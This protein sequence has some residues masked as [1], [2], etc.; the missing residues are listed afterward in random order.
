MKL[1]FYDGPVLKFDQ[2]ISKRWYGKT[3][4]KSERKAKSNLT[5]QYKKQYGFNPNVKISLP[6]KIQIL[7]G[8]N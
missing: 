8:E 6:G 2:Q 4:A 5:F 1:Y 7:E 3:Y